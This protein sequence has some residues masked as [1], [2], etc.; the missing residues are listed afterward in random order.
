MPAKCSLNITVIGA[1]MGGLGTAIALTE[2][3]HKVTILEQAPDFVEIGAGVQVPPNSSREL[4]R[5]GLKEQMEKI[6]SRPSRINYRTWD[7]GVPQGFTDMA[8]MPKK[9][10]APYWQVFRP[11]YH[12][13]LYEAALA[14]GVEVRKGQTVSKYNPSVPSVELESGEVVH[15]DL[16]VAAD[17]V[18]SVARSA[19]GKNTEPHETGDTC[20]R[21]VIP[22]EKLLADPELAELSRDPNFEQFLGPDHHI[23][24]YNMQREKTFNLLMVIPDD[25]KMKGYRAPTNASEVRDAYKGWSPM[26]QKLLSF[27]PDEVEKWRLID[28]PPISD[29][30]HPDGKMV[31]LGDAVH[32]TLPYLAQGAAMAIEDSVVLGST[33]SHLQSKDDLPRLLNLFY[34][35]RVGRAQTIQR[36]SATNRFFIHMRQPEQLAM[37]E[38]V[39]RTGDYPASPN[40]MGNTLFQ[41][42]LYG[43]DAT[44]DAKSW[45]KREQQMSNL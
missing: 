5:W 23:I 42:W 12:T 11:D 7:T 17:G 31:L 22:R 2:A 15:S 33:L 34:R 25:K 4:I 8:Q 32:A 13:V 21:V 40:L 20:F 19:M 45:W 6:A 27:L 1:G 38:E 37:R 3:G 39:F 18:K 35:I 9:Y 26:V 43:Y 44:E 24:G 41:Q 16:I 36:G 10:G 14:K 28:L 29:W 30:V